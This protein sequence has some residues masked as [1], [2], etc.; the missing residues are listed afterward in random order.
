MPPTAAG[1]FHPELEAL[2]RAEEWRVSWRRGARE[3]TREFLPQLWGARSQQGTWG[4][5]D[6]GL[7]GH[8]A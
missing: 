3:G 1:P 2:P 6:T 4:G 8:M 5:V 7:N